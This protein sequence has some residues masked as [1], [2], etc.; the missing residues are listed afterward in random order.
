MWF[1]GN[2]GTTDKTGTDRPRMSVGKGREEEEEGQ[3]A[4]GGMNVE[5]EGAGYVNKL[6]ELVEQSRGKVPPVCVGRNKRMLSRNYREPAKVR[7]GLATVEGV[8]V[9][10]SVEKQRLG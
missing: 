1:R 6:L 2:H 3:R 10:E 8:V 4:Q 5:D 9:I 7:G